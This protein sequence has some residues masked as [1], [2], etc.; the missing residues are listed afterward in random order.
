MPKYADIRAEITSKI[1]S[2]EWPPGTRLPSELELCE[3]YGCSRGTVAKALAPLA[4]EGLIVR[5]RRTGTF[6][7]STI[8]PRVEEVFVGAQES[9]SEVLTDDLRRSIVMELRGEELCP[10]DLSERLGVSLGRVYH[11]LKV[12]EDVELVEVVREARVRGTVKR[13]YTTPRSGGYVMHST[14]AES[15]RGSFRD[16]LR[17]GLSQLDHRLDEQ[18]VLEDP[19]E[20]YIA[21]SVTV[22]ASPESLKELTTFLG[23]WVQR[24]LQVQPGHP[25]VSLTTTCFPVHPEPAGGVQKS[26]GGSAASAEGRGSQGDPA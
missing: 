11:H 4:E 21:G 26:A 8:A 12:L 24:H 15:I 19:P 22:N 13:F 1:T 7:A 6:V 17:A 14:D 18:R 5:R 25:R 16:I 3:R 20:M 9:Q 2:R 10:A 23:G